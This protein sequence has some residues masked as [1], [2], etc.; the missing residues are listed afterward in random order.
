MPERGHGGGRGCEEEEKEKGKVVNICY[1]GVSS[2]MHFVIAF[3]MLNDYFVMEGLHQN[4]FFFWPTSPQM[5]FHHENLHACK[6]N[7]KVSC[8]N[9]LLNIFTIFQIVLF[10]QDH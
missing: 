2:K 4:F 5:S 7:I 1:S 9:L 8:K 6:G 10:I 3:L